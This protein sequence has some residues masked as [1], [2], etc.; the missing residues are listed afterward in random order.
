MKILTKDVDLTFVKMIKMGWDVIINDVPFEVVALYDE[1]PGK[2]YQNRDGVRLWAYP[3]NT[4][5]TYET[6]IPFESKEPVAWGIHYDPYNDI[7]TKF[8]DSIDAHGTVTITRNG[9][10]FCF[11]GHGMNYG[12]DNA[13]V[14][15]SK[16][17]EHPLGLEQVDYDKKMI[18]RKVWWRSEPAIITMYFKG[19]GSVILEPDGIDGFTIPA[20]FLDDADMFDDRESCKVSIFDDHVC[21][22][23]D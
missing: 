17:K 22:F 4:Q 7:N 10:D 23:R 13:R 2:P 20:E 11:A 19:Q 14:M 3:K 16:I 6:L 5:P 18:G 9:E 1:Y 21:W 15:I 8:H 12:I